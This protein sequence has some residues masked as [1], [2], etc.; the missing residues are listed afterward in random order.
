MQTFVSDGIRLGFID[1]S[2]ANVH[3]A[4]G[5]GMSAIHF[6]PGVNLESEFVAR[7]ALP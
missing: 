1:D 7:D 6:R 5:L 4:E 2:I 3:A